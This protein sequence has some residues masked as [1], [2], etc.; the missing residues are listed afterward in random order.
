MKDRCIC[1][2]EKSLSLLAI[3]VSNSFTKIA[4]FDGL[5][6]EKKLTVPT[7]QLKKG[8]FRQKLLK[9]KYD[10]VVISSVVPGVRS[11]LEKTF[12]GSAIHWVTNRS[13][14]GIGIDYPKPSSIGADRLCNAVACSKLFGKPAIVVDF[15]TAVTFDVISSR[16]DYIGGIIAPGLNA[17]T[18]YLHERTAL[19][20]RVKLKEPRSALGKSTVEAIRIGAVIGYRGLIRGLLI[21]LVEEQFSKQSPVLVATGGDAALIASAMPEFAAVDPDLTLQGV[22]II[23]HLAFKQ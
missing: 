11:A 23:G 12:K 21:A 6:I 19:L 1:K 16:G 20:P 2:S 9:W 8:I 18:D 15:G 17:M 14:L 10:A 22:C 7:P 3:D 4:L 13:P 5:D